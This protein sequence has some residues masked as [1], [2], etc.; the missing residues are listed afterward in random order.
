GARNESSVLFSLSALTSAASASK[1]SVS[2]PSSPGVTEDS[3]LIDLKALTA[4]ASSV[5]DNPLA[6][7][8]GLGAPAPLGAAPL[9]VAPL[10]VAPLGAAPL[11]GVT[12]AMDM[13]M[14]PQP[15]NRNGLF[16]GG[17]IVVAA[18]PVTLILQLNGSKEQPVA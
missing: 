10:G 3:G 1:P 13:A 17:G 6:P 15:K 14:P 18:V 9:G 11:G 2:Q 5:G 4:A 8:P 12:T 7:A 16:I